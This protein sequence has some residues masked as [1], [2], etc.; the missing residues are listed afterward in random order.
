MSDTTGW[1]KIGRTSYAKIIDGRWWFIEHENSK[2]VLCC[3]PMRPTRPTLRECQQ[4]AHATA[5]LWA[6]DNE[7][8]N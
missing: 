2:W 3:G 7:N 8:G 4:L 6:G 5:R 1:K